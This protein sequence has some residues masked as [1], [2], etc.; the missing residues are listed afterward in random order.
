[1]LD[2]VIIIIILFGFIV[3]FKRGFILQLIHL[4]SFIISFTIAYLYY[5]KLAPKLLLWIPYPQL[6]DDSTMQ[7][8]FEQAN[9]DDVYYRAISFI[10]IFFSVKILLRIIGSMLDFVA[11]L[12]V[13]KQLNVWAGGILGFLEVYLILFLLLYI[14][15]LIPVDIIQ[16][17]LNNSIVAEGI[18]KHTPIFSKQIYNMWFN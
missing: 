9:L 6:G 8:M 12:P 2:I 10:I 4:T 5:D 11:H 15:A 18:V 3:G 17:S 13:L 1:M 7:L 14:A 16:S